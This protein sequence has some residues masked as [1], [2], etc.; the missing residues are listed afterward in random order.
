[1]SSCYDGSR[2]PLTPVEHTKHVAFDKRMLV[3]GF[4]SI[5]RGTLPLLARHIDMQ[6]SQIT[7]LVPEDCHTSQMAAT[8]AERLG[9]NLVHAR[10]TKDNYQSVLE[11]LLSDGDFLVNL[12]VDVGSVDLIRFCAA[13]N[14]L[15]L[16]TVVEPWLGGYSSPDLTPSQRSNYAQREELLAAAREL[17]P[18]APTAVC[19]HGANPGLVSHFVK[20]A[21]LNIARDTDEPVAAVPQTQAEW[22]DLAQRLGVKTIHIAERDTQYAAERKAIGEFVNTWSV[23]GFI[24]EGCHQP[25]ELGWGTHE[26]SLP[27]DGHHHTFGT[28]V[29][30]YLDR[31]GCTTKVRTWTPMEGPFH[32]FLVTH[33]ESISIADFFSKRNKAGETEY[34]PTVHYAYHPCDDAVL[35]MH[36]MAGKN[37]VEQKKKRLIVDEIVAGVDELGVLLCGHKKGAYWFGSQLDTEFARAAEP[38]NSATTLQVTATVMA[39]VIWAIEN[40][41]RGILEADQIDYRRVLEIAGP[42]CQPIVGEYTDWTPLQDRGE[43][44]S[45]DLDKEDPFQFKNFRVI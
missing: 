21:L 8:F 39:G 20:Q 30:I 29:A 37:F 40:P 18:N 44:F 28:N 17:G 7:V 9:T 22:V 2:Q 35:S 4:G 6:P 38:H 11:P 36:E 19:C 13:N 3:I 45:E 34:R 26:K 27:F 43:L 12:S 42:Y 31:P 23:D 10:L 33:N 25:S 41:R 15:Y 1:M 5:G 24:S 14:V 32:G 16:D